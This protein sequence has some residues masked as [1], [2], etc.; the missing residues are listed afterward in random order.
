MFDE[1]NATVSPSELNL[2]PKD[3]EQ[4]PPKEVEETARVLAESLQ[5]PT[6]AF[7][8]GKNTL[9]FIVPPSEYARARLLSVQKLMG[10][11]LDEI[12]GVEEQRALLSEFLR[13]QSPE[14]R[15]EEVA[16]HVSS[17]LDAMHG[18]DGVGLSY[19]AGGRRVIV[20]KNTFTG[21]RKRILRHELLHSMATDEEDTGSGF[22]DSNGIGHDLNE[23]SVE[24]MEIQSRQSNPVF[25]PLSKIAYVSQGLGEHES[26]YIYDLYQLGFLIEETEHTGNP[27]SHLDIAR[28]H[29]AS[30]KNPQEKRDLLRETL[31]ARVKQ[32]PNRLITTVWDKL[33]NPPTPRIRK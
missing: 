27:L 29:F 31:L 17:E 14:L 16:R 6:E 5:T 4:I 26:P 32:P 12:D 20:I 13:T 3:S 11:P 10:R 1:S 2:L 21:N 30:G 33:V 23:A 19:V 25:S 9:A 24:V 8:N 22:Q 15:E 18:E 7:E 28:F